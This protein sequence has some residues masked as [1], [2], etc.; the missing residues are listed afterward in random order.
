M[1]VLDAAGL[2]P[3][4]RTRDEAARATMGRP[5][6]IITT[7]VS[8]SASTE[9]SDRQQLLL[10]DCIAKNEPILLRGVL[11]DWTPTKRW[12][13]DEYLRATEPDA[14]LE[15]RRADVA[16]GRTSTQGD[17]Y[18]REK[19]IGW[20]ALVDAVAEAARKQ[21]NAPLYAAQ[22]RVR[23]SLPHL[24]AD[25]RPE[26]PCVAA[27]G[28]VWRNAPSLYYGCGSKTPLHFDLLENVLC[29]ARGRKRVTLWHPE[30]S[31]VLYPADDGAATF[32]RADVYAPDLD[33]FPLLSEG[34]QRGAQVEVHAGD[35]LY[36]PCCWWHAVST[37]RGEC[38]MSVSYWA[39]QPA[40]KAWQ[41]PEPDYNE[42][43]GDDAEP[44]VGF[45]VTR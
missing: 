25:T 7:T 14:V 24:F 11:S 27:L 21:E 28:P 9:P 38:S 6:S 16:S 41:P 2:A 8:S 44:P 40:E 34:L 12:H 23:T 5:S 45:S 33:A 18:E 29:V 43:D 42:E 35:A 3:R 20:P 15:P 39:Q 36:I 13:D 19:P 26:P 1:S 17:P 10:A 22:V 32:S 30:D 4:F 37:P 31:E